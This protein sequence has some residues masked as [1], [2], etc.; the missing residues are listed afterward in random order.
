M[1]D[2][3][4]LCLQRSQ[5]NPSAR[6]QPPS[7]AEMDQMYAQFNAWRDKFRDNIV[8]LGG[9]LGAKSRIVTAEGEI[10]GPFMELKELIGGYMI[11]SAASLEAAVEIAKQCPGVVG[12]GSSLEVRQISTP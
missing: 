10:D 9:R 12:P 8:D 1:S 6:R 2:S 11:V 4:Y 5:P 7:P 3:K